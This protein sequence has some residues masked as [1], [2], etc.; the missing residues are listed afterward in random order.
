MIKCDIAN[1]KLASREAESIGEETLL[2][3]TCYM[4]QE[5]WSNFEIGG[6]GRG[7]PLVTQYWGGHKTLFLTNSVAAHGA[8]IYVNKWRKL[9]SVT[10]SSH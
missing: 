2:L 10:K 4:L 7:A 8:T 3:K 6:R 5:P 1:E 9:R